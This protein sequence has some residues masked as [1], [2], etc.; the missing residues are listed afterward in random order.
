MTWWERVKE[1]QVAFL[2][3]CLLLGGVLSTLVLSNAFL[4]FRRYSS[5]VVSVTG[6]ASKP[7]ISNLATWEGTV[8]RRAMTMSEAYQ[9]LKQ[10]TSKV[11]SYLISKGLPEKN[12]ALGQIYTETVYERNANG[13]STNT[14]QDFIMRQAVR[15]ESGNVDLVETV[16]RD[17]ND[18]LNQG[19]TLD[20]GAPQYFYTKLDDLKVEMLGKATQNAKQRA[21][22]M[23][24]STGN[25]IG[26]M[27]SSQMG[28]FQITPEN[29]T[30]VA[31]YGINDTSSKR[32]KVTA[33]VSV[34]FAVE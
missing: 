25:R 34:S 4:E 18:L 27:R 8:S 10:D 32:K 15:V 16:A 26:L 9:A 3:L 21:Q 28:V 1:A 6:A 22:S 31:D 5:Q 29:S 20:A 23:A 30:E 14:I 33:V 11:R 12:I 7:I 17:V 13:S 24:S 19:L 2:G